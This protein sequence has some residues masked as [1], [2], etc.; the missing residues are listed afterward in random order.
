MIAVFP[1]ASFALSHVEQYLF[2]RFLILLASFN[3]KPLTRFNLY[4]PN[5]RQYSFYKTI[6]QTLQ[7]YPRDQTILCGDFNKVIVPSLDTSSKK[8]CTILGDISVAL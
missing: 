3:N 2:G 5:T 4:A 1:L 8:T 6:M 7:H